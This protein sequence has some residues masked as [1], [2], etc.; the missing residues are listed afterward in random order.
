MKNNKKVVGIIGTRGIPNNYG[1]FERFVEL[2]AEK[3][4]QKSNIKLVIF[5]EKNDKPN[6]DPRKYKYVNLIS[7]KSSGLLYYMESVIRATKSCDIIF[8]CGVGISI[9]S[10]IPKFFGKKLIINPDGCEWKRKKWSILGRTIIKLMYYPTLLFADRI[11]I[12][13]E[14]LKSD[15]GK[16]FSK[17]YVYIPYQCPDLVFAKTKQVK[18][19]LATKNIDLEDLYYLII[20]RLEPENSIEKICEAFINHKNKNAQLIIVGK[21]DTSYFINKLKKYDN[22]NL[23]IKFAGGIY[24][25]SLLNQLRK[26]AK[27]YLHGHTVGGTNPSLIEALATCNGE[28]VCHKNK[29]NN[30][31]AKKNAVYFSDVESLVKIFDQFKVNIKNINNWSDERFNSKKIYEK[32]MCEF[33]K[34]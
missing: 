27:F 25:Q 15:F 7:K 13:S 20:A 26:N 34:V 31:V 30:E 4:S 22:Y 3:H 32:Y 14:A 21:T 10:M 6:H 28:I 18:K 17:K 16:L 33:E 8:C 5:G 23:K 11:I 19:T 1:G 24:N 12:D 9:G 2:L 29:Y